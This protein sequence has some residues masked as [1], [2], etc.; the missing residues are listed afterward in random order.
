MI[1]IRC[2]RACRNAGKLLL[3]RRQITMQAAAGKA[4]CLAMT[5]NV[6]LVAMTFQFVSGA[7][8]EPDGGFNKQ[9]V[10]IRV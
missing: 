9:A 6:H 5:A 10:S 3:L 4:A 2:D 7:T 1:V 8:L